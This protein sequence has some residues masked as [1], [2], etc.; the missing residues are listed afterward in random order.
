MKLWQKGYELNR[1]VEK[2]TVGHDPLID[3]NLVKYDCIASMAHAKMLNK[4]GILSNNELTELEKELTNIIKL[5]QMNKFKIKIEDEDCHTAIENHLIKKLG[6]IG[7]KIH[8][9]RSRND[10]VLTAIRLYSKDNLK[11]IETSL[12]EFIETLKKV[13][14]KYEDVEIPGYTHSRKAMPYSVGRY[15]EAFKEA[16]EDDMLLLKL[17]YKINDQNPLGSAA[18]Y[19]V[20]LEIDRDL[21]T[22]LLDFSK[23]QK[24]E[25]Y[26]QNSRGKF[27]SIILFALGQIM[28]DL[29]KLA[30]DLIQF[31]MDEFGYFSLPDEFCTGSSLMPHKKNPDVLELIRA[32]SAVIISYYF[33]VIGIVKGLLSGY[34][35]D[36]QLT[37][38]P[39]MKSFDITLDTLKI[40][41]LIVINLKVNRENCKRACSEEIY[42]VEKTYNLV[43]KGRAF[44]DAYQEVSKKL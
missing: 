38:E 10:Q 4:I 8:T 1:Q 16:F 17:A 29:Q 18:G 19:G 21:T 22:E 3:L 15:F 11:E 20:N 32:K 44:R 27:E 2:Y 36:L 25:L 30:N 14:M 13:S 33:Q 23:T 39:L 28:L 37:K 42:S 5:A 35:R 6:E 43:K 34:S 12:L 26:C 31:S 7:K 41:N 9:A 40:M 24:N